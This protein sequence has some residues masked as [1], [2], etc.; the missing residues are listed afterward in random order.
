MICKHCNKSLEVDNCYFIV[1]FDG[2]IPPSTSPLC[3][4]CAEMVRMY[5]VPD[6]NG[7]VVK[8][9]YAQTSSSS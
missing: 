5:T 8:V 3:S 1:L 2:D 9:T 4:F 7:I 6:H